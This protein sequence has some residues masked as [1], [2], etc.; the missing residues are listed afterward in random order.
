MVRRA[1][2]AVSDGKHKVTGLEP[3]VGVS[4]GSHGSGLKGGAK[5]SEAVEVVYLREVLPVMHYKWVNGL[6]ER[7]R[8]KVSMANSQGRVDHRSIEIIDHVQA[9]K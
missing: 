7:L 3:S 4:G 1:V 6:V 9:H 8:H 5:R 2:I